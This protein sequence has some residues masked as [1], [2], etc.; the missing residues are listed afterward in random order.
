MASP[1]TVA[2][3]PLPAD[4]FYRGA[5][6]ML[7][8]SSV[9]ALLTTGKL[10]PITMVLAPAAILFKGYRWWHGYPPEWRQT[11]ATRLVVA[12]LFVVPVDALFISR[13]LA[14]GTPN[15]VLYA[16]LLAA[17]HFLLYVTI[18][19]LYSASTD[20]DA[21]F[22]A[23][24]SF[25]GVLAAAVFTVDTFFLFFFVVFLL[26][27]VATF[28][29]LEIRRGAT[30]AIFPAIEAQPDRRHQFHRALAMAAASVAIGAVVI[31]SLLFFIFPRFS[32]GFF[33]HAG[34]QP[35]LMSGF[36]DNV[37]LGQIGEIKKNT[38]VV[39]RVKTGP[40]VNYP[41]LR[42]R[43]IALTKFDGKRWTGGSSSRTVLSANYDGWI[44]LSDP[45]NYEGK[46]SVELHYTV[47]L[48]PLAS[49]SLFA[50]PQLM[51]LRGDFI[52]DNVQ[53]ANLFIDAAGSVYNPY[54]NFAQVR[55]EGVSVLPVSRPAEA[56]LASTDYPAEIRAAYLQL[57]AL[58]PRIPEFA[59]RI[60]ASAKNSFDKAVA[61]ENYFHRNFTYSL[62]LTGRPGAD[63][64]AHFLF[65]TR[66][67]HCEYFASAMAVM[68]RTLGIPSREVNG[69]LP[70]EYND[71]AG[72]YI[73]RAS[74]A[75]SWV[76]AYFPGSGWITFDPTP[77]SGDAAAGGIFARLDQYVDWMQL[78]W[79]EWIINYDFSHQVLL[80]R[81][82]RQNSMDWTE[83]AR[84]WYF[85]VQDRG[86]HTLSAWQTSHS[87]LS[88]F[89][90]LLLVLVLI[91]FRLDW[92]RR[93]VHWLSL[94]W[95]V[96][97]ST[98]ERS[99]PQ[100]ASRLY[101]ELLRLLEKRGF[102]RPATQTPSEFA[103][104]L[105]LPR[106]LDSAVGEF[107]DLYTRSR[108]GDQPCDALRLRSLLSQIRSTPR[109]S[110]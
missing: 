56:R 53:R 45:K 86:M 20:R 8:L 94:A 35:S 85:G 46:P 93:L 29:G 10:D 24:L 105:S 107:T 7:V 90:P 48:Q 64:L 19:R 84:R 66:A 89:F 42:W 54:Q 23:M 11:T 65:E 51:S 70:G 74:D 101:A 78:N 3:L 75:H 9:V 110:A 38:S 57:P 31:G 76:E 27:G 16:S 68:L 106:G 41:L 1:A 81:N 25:A 52:G 6:F 71:V 28:V 39:M 47:L 26:F 77:P 12:Y 17:V 50:P 13:G 5:L 60:T 109:R 97:F 100:L 4:R 91:I 87:L 63:P 69:F 30:G 96:N 49:N 55:Y 102:T 72:D 79:N 108:F 99:N 40:P 37:E 67:G 15:P 61:I 83:A 62:N 88:L 92:I 34:L 44:T 43:G 98:P 2:S 73:V 95:Q 59:L 22:L 32:A 36:T 18:V 58:D 104:S 80:A 14:A 33:A 103:A 21:A 82:M